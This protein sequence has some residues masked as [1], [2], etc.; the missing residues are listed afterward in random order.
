MPLLELLLKFES[1]KLTL[2]EVLALIPMMKPRLYSISSS[3]LALPARVSI[4]VGVLRAHTSSGREHRGVCSNFL[5]AKS[6]GGK[7]WASIRDTG[8]S[9]RLPAPP[10][11]M[12]LVGPGTGLAPLRG[13][14]QEI[15]Q[16]RKQGNTVGAVHLFF[17]CRKD[18]DFL[19]EDQLKA[20]EK[21]GT[22]TKLHVA[23]SRMGGTRNYVQHLMRKEAAS[24]WPILKDDGHVFVCGDASSMAP[25]VRETLRL[26][27]EQEGGLGER[28]SQNFMEE[29]RSHGSANRYHEDV[30]A[31]NA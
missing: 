7:I 30:W 5:A 9:F 26:I 29:I 11:P 18:A 15:Q 6:V 20:F 22:L 28:G 3:P 23:F 24:L 16:Q 17:G 4:T 31:G 14:L 25:E 13:F 27:A 2:P 8:S 12:I 21:D 10:A 1:I 19:Y